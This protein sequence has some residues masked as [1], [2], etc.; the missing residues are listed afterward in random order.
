MT[1]PLVLMPSATMFIEATISAVV[2][3]FANCSPTWRLRD[4]GLMQV[5]SRSPKPV[6]PEKV[7]AAPP[8]ATPRRVISAKPRVMTMARVFSPTPSP[9]AMPAEMAITFLSGP[10]SSQPMTS[11]LV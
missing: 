7:S 8:S 4:S 1:T 2:R 5:V 11:V 3:P 10:P 6:R 9:S